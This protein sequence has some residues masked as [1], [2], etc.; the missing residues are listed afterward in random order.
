VKKEVS[1]IHQ[2]M[3]AT[4]ASSAEERV[5]S[6]YSSSEVNN[7][8]STTKNHRYEILKKIGQGLKVSF[9]EGHYHDHLKSFRF[10]CP[11]SA[12]QTKDASAISQNSTDTILDESQYLDIP[13][14]WDVFSLF[15]EFKKKN[16]MLSPSTLEESL[17][18][19]N[20]DPSSDLYC[21]VGGFLFPNLGDQTICLL[22]LGNLY[23]ILAVAK[24]EL[25]TFVLQLQLKIGIP[26]RVY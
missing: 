21:F 15:T 19:M 6:K 4:F 26:I 9:I 5:E 12:D 20:V 2:L 23:F 24:K 25:E 8:N 7:K 13:H 3:E 22:G 10:F 16:D 11:Q 17:S 18:F 1:L 14:D